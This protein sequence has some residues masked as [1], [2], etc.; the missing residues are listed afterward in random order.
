MTQI[1]G[2]SPASYAAAKNLSTN[3]VL[4]SGFAAAITIIS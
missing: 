1:M 3:L 4:G 2:L